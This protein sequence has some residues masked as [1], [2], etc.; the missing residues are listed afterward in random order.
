MTQIPTVTELSER[1]QEETGKEDFGDPGCLE[2][3]E[4]YLETIRRHV[5]D[6]AGQ[7]KL[8]KIQY[9]KL[10]SRLK[11]FAA[12][13]EHPEILQQQINAPIFVTGLP[14][15]GTSALLNLLAVDPAA[16]P[17]LQWELRHPEPYPG[18]RPGEMDPRYQQL[19]AHMSSLQDS[20]FRKM[21]YADAD[22]P[23]ECVLLHQLSF[24][25]VQTG[26]EVML[27]PYRSWFIEHDL[28][29]LYAEYK[30]FLKLLQWQRPADYWVL[31]APAHMWAIDCVAREFPDATVVWGHRDPVRVSASIC[32]LTRQ[33][34][35]LYMGDNSHIDQR[36]F[37][38]SVMDFYAESLHRGLNERQRQPQLQFLDYNHKEL[39][40]KP[41]VL[42]EAIFEA[43]KRDF[44]PQI[45]TRFQQHI[46]E[47]PQHKHGEH[48]YTLEQFGLRE[49]DIRQRFHFYSFQDT[50]LDASNER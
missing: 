41:M 32:S 24:D 8:L 6:Q 14:R 25:G 27:E 20:E 33:V 36:E 28:S 29:R 44:N 22:T 17:L 38:Y 42:L 30:N 40:D 19:V 45:A 3:L 18:L 31:K 23:E 34:M 46:S 43:S 50:Y 21:H 37:A 9:K 15:S 11:I 7:Q 10:V 26:F 48:R 47:H 1:A 2:G 4:V 39:L 5:P 12:F 13:A 49:E 16:R 35:D